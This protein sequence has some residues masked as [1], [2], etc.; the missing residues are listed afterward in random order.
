MN[1]ASEGQVWDCTFSS[2]VE[3][4][5]LMKLFSIVVRCDKAGKDKCSPG[6]DEVAINDFLARVTAGTA[7]CTELSHDFIQ[8]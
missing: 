6:E 7:P 8:R 4:Q 1:S 2:D 3:N 5:R